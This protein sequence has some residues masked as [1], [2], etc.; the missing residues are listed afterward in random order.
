[1]QLPSIVGR[2]AKGGPYSGPV[3]PGGGQFGTVDVRDSG[4]AV[5]VTLSGWNWEPRR[6]FSEVLRFPAPR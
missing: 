4:T 1:M 6:L 5:E 3:M 2:M